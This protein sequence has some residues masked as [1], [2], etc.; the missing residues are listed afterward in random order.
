[1]CRLLRTST[2]TSTH[3]HPHPHT[4]VNTGFASS[5][6]SVMTTWLP[7]ASQMSLCVTAT[8]CS[9]AWSVHKC[10]YKQYTICVCL[11]Q[12]ACFVASWHACLTRK[13]SFYRVDTMTLPHI[14]GFTFKNKLMCAC[15]CVRSAAF[16]YWKHMK[17]DNCELYHWVTLSH[18]KPHRGFS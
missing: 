5:D 15:L 13:V 9:A 14:N 11:W 18:A 8:R 2:P 6:L 12:H 4:Q 10:V 3:P 7:V 17:C 1:M 16:S